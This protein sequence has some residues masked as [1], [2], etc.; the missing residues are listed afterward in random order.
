MSA[1]D[2][3]ARKTEG[4][5]ARLARTLDVLHVAT[6]LELGLRSFVTYDRRQQQLAR[7][8]GL[9]AISPRA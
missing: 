5:D 4:F 8:T 3:Y 2:L 1:I 9:K 7:A 6:A